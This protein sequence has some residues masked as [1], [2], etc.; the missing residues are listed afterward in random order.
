MERGFID[1]RKDERYLIE[2]RGGNPGSIKARTNIII[3]V[4]GTAGSRPLHNN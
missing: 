4:A 1:A 2:A 3:A